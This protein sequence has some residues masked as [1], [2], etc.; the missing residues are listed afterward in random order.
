MYARF[1]Q[2]GDSIDYTPTSDVSAGDVVVLIDM[3]AI[4]KMDIP[5][6]TL[7]ALATKGV[8]EVPKKTGVDTTWPFGLQ[9]YWDTTNKQVTDVATGNRPI[10]YAVQAVTDSDTT[11]RIIFKQ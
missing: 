2:D 4:A 7:G 8:F 9:L 11:I 6:N 3:L 10:G 1:V 5:A